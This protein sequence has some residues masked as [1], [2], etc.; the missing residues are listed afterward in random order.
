M[1]LT[2]IIHSHSWRNEMTQKIIR[3]M[4]LT[5]LLLFAG[6]LHVSARTNAQVITLSVKDIPIQK[7]LTEIEKQSGYNF[8]YGSRRNYFY[9][10]PKMNSHGV[11][12]P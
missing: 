2:A 7:A 9:H 4:K 10:S 11:H 3:V 5:A 6:F 8:I 1:Q 12:T